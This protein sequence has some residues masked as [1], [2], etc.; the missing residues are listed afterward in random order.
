MTKTQVTCWVVSDG[1]IGME[2]QALGLAEALGLS[3]E[4]KRIAVKAPWRWLPPL[5]WRDPLRALKKS[6]DSLAPPW[7]DLV[8]ASGRQSVGPALAIRRA[9]RRRQPERPTHAI[10]VQDPKVPLDRFD[11]VISPQHDGLR[12]EN[13][14]QSLG[15]IHRVTKAR[16]GEAA[17]GFAASVASLPQRRLAVLLGGDNKVYRFDLAQA[18]KLGQELAAIAD[19]GVGILV[20]PSRRTGEA[21]IAAIAK[22]LTRKNAI[23]W[24]GR[25]ENPYYAYLALADQILVTCD[26]VNMTCEA[27]A[28]G[29]PVQVLML[30]G[31]SA[32]FE[33]F[34]QSLRQA[35]LTRVFTG[36]LESW[37]PPAFDEPQRIAGEVKKRLPRLFGAA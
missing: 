7:P 23:V 29:K 19:Q 28:T 37:Q 20:T 12:G 10:Y 25:S 17:K 34:H 26:S 13:V 18:Q 27:A 30:E 5:L 11:L 33:S 32:K 9:S 24:D 35:G 3:A 8:I 16:L 1:K 15:S 2:V 4:V 21:Q 22:A 6:G 31:G 14:I 36:Q